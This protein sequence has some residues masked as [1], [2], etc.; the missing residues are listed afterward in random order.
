MVGKSLRVVF[1]L[2]M[3][4]TIGQALF[5]VYVFSLN[6]AIYLKPG[7]SLFGSEIWTVMFEAFYFLP[8]NDVCVNIYAAIYY[9]KV[10]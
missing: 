10:I 2:D 6:L 1:L 8:P 9:L 3:Y 4:F 5:H 7:I